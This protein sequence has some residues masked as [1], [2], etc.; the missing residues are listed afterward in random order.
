M[1][2]KNQKIY[3]RYKDRYIPGQVVDPGST[4]T[5]VFFF[6][7]NFELFEHEDGCIERTVTT[8]HNDLIIDYLEHNR[9]KKIG[10]ITDDI[11]STN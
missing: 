4:L 9:N 5:T 11:E 10:I 1:F 3:Y 6:Q 7:K 2:T 8:I